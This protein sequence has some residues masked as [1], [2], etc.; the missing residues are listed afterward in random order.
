MSKGSEQQIHALARAFAAAHGTKQQQRT[1]LRRIEQLAGQ[2][3]V[4]LRLDPDSLAALSV[5]EL[6]HC[7]GTG[8]KQ[9]QL[10]TLLLVIE[11]LQQELG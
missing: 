2:A 3:L 10:R 7:L 6:R 11:A 1:V 4:D 5:E 8:F 9:R